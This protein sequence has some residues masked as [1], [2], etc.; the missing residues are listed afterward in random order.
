MASIRTPVS[1]NGKRMIDKTKVKS[2]LVITLSNVGDVVLTTPVVTTL[3]RALPHAR[4]S[5]MVG[6]AAKEIFEGDPKIS[7]LIVYDKKISFREKLKIAFSLRKSGY[8]VVIDL[9][10]TLFPFLIGSRY[11]TNPV[12]KAPSSIRHMIERHLWKLET[13]GISVL[14]DNARVADSGSR[15]KKHTATDLKPSLWIDSEAERYVDHFLHEHGISAGQKIVAISPGGR[16]VIKRW[17]KGGFIEIANR[18][19]SECKAKVIIIGSP[20]DH[21]LIE[22]I[23]IQVRNSI[24]ASGRTTLKQLGALLRRCALLISNDSAPMHIATAMETPVVAIFGPTDPE[25]YGP[26]GKRNV[27]VKRNLQCSPCEKAQCRLSHEC[28]E[29]VEPGEVFE[30]VKNVLEERYIY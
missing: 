22:E 2:I 6:P 25:K 29:L 8:D 13:V 24:D 1:C 3:A 7:E 26:L 28:M 17:E 19:Q 4:L 16:N 9:R 30:A 10:N 23:V 11:R 14:S 27:V 15:K 18:L 21:E 20:A 5:V 12:S